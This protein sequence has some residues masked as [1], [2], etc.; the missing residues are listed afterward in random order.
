MRIST[1]AHQR[2]LSAVMFLL[3]TNRKRTCLKNHNQLG[4]VFLE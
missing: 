4:K 2:V 1:L 3:L